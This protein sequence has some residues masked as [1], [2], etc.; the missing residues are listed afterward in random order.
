MEGGWTE[1]V[2]EAFLSLGLLMLDAATMMGG[3]PDEAASGGGRVPAC[4]VG[5]VQ[6]PSLV[7]VLSALAHMEVP[8]GGAVG[9]KPWGQRLEELSP[10]GRR[11][12][13]AFMLQ[14][15]WFSPADGSAPGESPG[16]LS[17]RLLAVLRALPIFEVHSG[18]AAPQ[19][20]PNE[21]IELSSG[22]GERSRFCRLDGPMEL[23][24]PPAGVEMDARLLPPCMLRFGSPVEEA[25]AEG[26]LGVQRLGLRDFGER[27]LVK[28]VRRNAWPLRPCVALH[29]V[30]GGQ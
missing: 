25:V 26:R 10:L 15:R 4:L 27:F 14:S 29:A 1:G 8:P 7:G 17:P 19:P 2:T 12:L 16:G 28:Q 18:G 6:P 30:E 23:F 21:P 9:A 11:Q 3:S 20:I 13:R 5:V 24:L 22:E